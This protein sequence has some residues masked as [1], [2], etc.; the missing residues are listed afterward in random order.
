MIELAR[1]YNRYG[2]KCTYCVNE[3]D[4]LGFFRDDSF[5][6]IYSSIV[7]QHIKPEYSKNYIREFLRVLAPGG[8]MVFQVPDSVATTTSGINLRIFVAYFRN[9]VKTIARRMSIGDM[10]WKMEMY[11][12]PKK[13]IVHLVS[14]HPGR[15]VDIQ[16]DRVAGKDWVSYRYYCV[17]E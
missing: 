8:I 1:Q 9:T 4:T 6:F 5:D 13:E 14:A 15:V 2:D 17:K 11:A 16:E 12:I 10:F 3:T 7:L